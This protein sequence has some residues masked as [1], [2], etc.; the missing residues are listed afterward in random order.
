[1]KST[2]SMTAHSARRESSRFDFSA[3]LSKTAKVGKRVINFIVGEKFNLGLLGVLALGVWFSAVL[4]SPALPWLAIAAMLSG[5]R[6]V[7]S[8]LKEGGG[9]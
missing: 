2:I 9:E 3:T 6:A 8:V 7:A 4:A 5:F 1:M